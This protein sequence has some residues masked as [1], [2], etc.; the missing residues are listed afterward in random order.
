MPWYIYAACKHLVPSGKWGSLFS[1]LSVLGVALGVWMLVVVNSVMN[2]FGD[3]IRKLMSESGGHI[4][5][6]LQPESSPSADLQSVIHHALKL[7]EV[8]TAA[9]F[10]ERRA[11]VQFENRVAL[12][13]VRSYQP[14]QDVIDLGVEWSPEEIQGFVEKGALLSAGLAASLKSG[15]GVDLDIYVPEMQAEGLVFEEEETA[16]FQFGTLT[17]QGV[18]HTGHSE[19]DA[20]TLFVSLPRMQELYQL[21][22]GVDGVALRLHEPSTAEQVALKLKPLLGADYT[23]LTWLEEHEDLFFI[24][25]LEK[26][27]ITL[28]L[29]VIS[30]VATFS[31]VITLFTSVVT[32]TG[33][34]GLYRSMGARSHEVGLVFALQ[35]MVI[36]LSG[37]SIGMSTALVTLHYRAEIVQFFYS[38]TALLYNPFLNLPASY[39]ATELL[40]FGLLAT[41]LATLSGVVPSIRAARLKPAEALRAEG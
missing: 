1:W 23:V 30:V 5:I 35:G 27:M 6:E 41:C 26:A 21:A 10:I 36:G 38:Q 3:H 16:P 20:N 40:V 2:G 39:T 19:V 14:D 25:K 32:K 15:T 24:V 7:P 22:D 12:P 31:I 11:M 13:H 17:I 37:A 29:L 8:D 4:D 18:V 34:I 9:T 33:E 28:V